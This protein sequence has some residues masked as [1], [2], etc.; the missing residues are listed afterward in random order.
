VTSL[1]VKFTC[2]MLKDDEEFKCSTA[3]LYRAL[4]DQQLVRAFTSSDAVVDSSKGGRFVLFGGNVTGE[5]ID[6]VPERKIEM[7]WRFK[8]WPEEHY[9]VVTIELTQQNDGTTLKLAQ[10]EVPVN[11][12]EKTREGWKNYYWRAIKQTFGYGAML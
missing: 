4:T 12:L 7:K 9:S 11:E 10:K 5:F 8:T 2:K 6:L 3:E 1:G